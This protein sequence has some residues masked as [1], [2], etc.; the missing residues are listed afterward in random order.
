M[1]AVP[2]GVR[3]IP[4]SFSRNQVTPLADLV[5]V[6]Q[7]MLIIAEFIGLRSI[8]LA[9]AFVLGFAAQSRAQV[10]NAAGKLA[11]LLR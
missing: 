6:E 4:L 11:H 8:S 5:V 3:N 9:P 7:G 10:K 1:P 2:P